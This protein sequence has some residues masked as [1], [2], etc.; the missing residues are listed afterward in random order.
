MGQIT[1]AT[2]GRQLTQMNPREQLKQTLQKSWPRI[3][4]V[5]GNNLSP[6]RLYQLCLSTINREPK[7]AE[8][9]VESVLGCFMKCSALGLEPSS[10]DGLGRAYILP[11]G[12]KNLKGQR[13][14]TFIL[15]YKGMIDLARRSGQLKSIHAQAVYEGDEFEC[16]EDETGQH[17]KYRRNPDAP[18]SEKT[19]TDVFVNAQLL[20]DGFV[21]EHMTK[22]EVEAVKRRSPAGNKGPWRTDYEA[23]ALKTVVRRSFKWLPVSVEAQAAAASDE[24][25]PDYSDVFRPVI[26]DAPVDVVDVQPAPPDDGGYD[27]TAAGT[28]LDAKRFDV[29][30]GFKALGVAD[31]REMLAAISKVVGREVDSFESLTEA[32]LDRTLDDLAHGSRK[33]GE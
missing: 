6:Q 10:V 29:V 4:Q 1:Q 33:D 8:C 18:H 16:W 20:P 26:D 19:L 25:T 32:E 31:E 28:A 14:A 27:A 21:F 30:N 2:Q 5:I 11:Y 9:S 23:M 7:L 12:N 24:T 13:E 22:S 3:Q 15:G 17:F